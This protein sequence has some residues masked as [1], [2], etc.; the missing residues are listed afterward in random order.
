MKSMESVSA[1]GFEGCCAVSDLLV[2]LDCSLS[3]C[4][5]SRKE[6]S[7]RTC[8]DLARYAGELRSV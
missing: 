7:H 4:M 5:R 3:G 1:E 2:K 6:F 8:D